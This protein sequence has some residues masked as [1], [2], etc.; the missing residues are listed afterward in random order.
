MAPSTTI[1]GKEG[2]EKHFRGWQLA[3]VAL[4]T[5]L[6]GAVLALPRPIPPR[7]LP[8]PAVD[9]S[10][11]RESEGRARAMVQTAEATPLP[12]LVRAAGEA[13]RR[14]GEGEAKGDPD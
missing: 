9:R 13:F 8:L 1:N 10:E 7:E 2:W 5:A 4:G 12:F 3:V 14:F 11:Q 6:G